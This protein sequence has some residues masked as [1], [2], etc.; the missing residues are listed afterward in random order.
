MAP[1]GRCWDGGRCPAHWQHWG[2][3]HTCQRCDGRDQPC[4][5]S[6]NNLMLL[7]VE[8]GGSLGMCPCPNKMLQLIAAGGNLSCSIS[9]QRCGTVPLQSR[10][11][12]SAGS[13][14]VAACRWER[15]LAGRE[16]KCLLVPWA[17]A[18]PGS[19]RAITG[20]ERSRCSSVSG[21]RTTAQ[22]CTEPAPGLGLGLLQL[23]GKGEGVG[24]ERT[25]I[26][27]CCRGGPRTSQ[28]SAASPRAVLR[29]PGLL[30]PS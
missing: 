7:Q 10:V 27:F 30:A 17:S 3:M 11:Q 25:G 5:C 20:L 28:S 26:F 16:H 22:S 4:L 18:D 24:E 23:D 13:V 2:Y 9:D 15:V 8:E 1:H 19:I 6:V 29:E 12:S 21:H 14:P